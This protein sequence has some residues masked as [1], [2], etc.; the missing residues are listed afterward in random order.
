LTRAFPNPLWAGMEATISI[1]ASPERPLAVEV[2]ALAPL[3]D[4]TS[5]M[6]GFWE[7]RFDGLEDLLGRMDQ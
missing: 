1:R 3:V 5:Q 4:G 2:R 7:S 6:K